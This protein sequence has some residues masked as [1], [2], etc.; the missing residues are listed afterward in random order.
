MTA[1]RL[2]VL[3]S[4]CVLS[5]SAQQPKPA[6]A[7]AQD[8][9][10]FF[11]Q[12]FDAYSGGDRPIISIRL[13][14]PEDCARIVP[15]LETSAKLLMQVWKPENAAFVLELAN[16][17]SQCAPKE[18]WTLLSDGRNY[19]IERPALAGEKRKPAPFGVN[20][21][22]DAF[23]LIWHRI[24]VA[25]LLR[26]DA[27]GAATVYLDTLEWRYVTSPAA[28]A[29]HTALDPRFLLMRAMVAEF[30]AR[31]NPVMTKITV[32]TPSAGDASA[33]PG[34]G[35][36]ARSPSI[37]NIAPNDPFGIVARALEGAIAADKTGLV[38]PEAY[39]RLAAVRLA[40][41]KPADALAAIDRA[42]VTLADNSLAYWA[43]LWR[44]RIL[45]AL[46]RQADAARAYQQALD[47]WP[48]GQAAGVGLALSLFKQNLRVEAA[49]AA[50]RVEHFPP[51][52][53]DPWWA[54]PNG[55]ARF[56]AAWLSDL[57]GTLR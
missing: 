47:V 18:F 21:D 36:S 37:P 39:V 12:L 46:N 7:A 26:A 14:T 41:G 11:D 13:K 6:P 49:D 55:D 52:S 20:I 51:A 40:E 5:V 10:A 30:R 53:P 17:V 16:T 1:L 54:Y 45:D 27:T 42:K 29:A 32:T 23:E 25:I 2:A 3:C 43:A 34:V 35:S 44:G 48:T 9:T 38:A 15:A 56:I 57:R 4:V 33:G 22:D 50:A 19:V 8:A 24:A 31:L 28:K